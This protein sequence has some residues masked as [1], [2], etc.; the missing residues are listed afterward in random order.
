MAGAWG[1]NGASEDLWRVF[2]HVQTTPALL[3]SSAVRPLAPG[4]DQ[5]V[6]GLSDGP[7]QQALEV[8]SLP[9]SSLFASGMWGF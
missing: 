3:S 9:L 7:T 4:P 6:H 5:E 8:V 2:L 1:A